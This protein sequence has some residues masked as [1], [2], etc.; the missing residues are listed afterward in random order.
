[1]RI[2]GKALARSITDSLRREIEILGTSPR[3]LLVYAGSDPVIDSYISIK[4][5]IADAIG[6]S[7][8]VVRFMDA[9]EE[10]LVDAIKNTDAD[11]VVVQLPLPPEINGEHILNSIPWQKDID[12]LSSESYARF[13][14]G[15]GPAI[16]PVAGA[17]ETVLSSVGFDC[18]GK[19][20]AVVGK[21]R[22]VGLPVCTW[23]KNQG[24]APL[25]LQ[26]GDDLSSLK[27][28]DLII[29]GTGRP[30]LLIDAG[31]SVEQ[32]VAR[33]DIDPACEEKASY[34]SAVPGGI[35]PITVAVLFRNLYTLISLRN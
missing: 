11:G 1:M 5:K 12:V 30:H 9:T 13:E 22:L 6:I 33:G 32:G 29:S 25:V 8:D 24:V 28:A 21:G 18:K 3:V 10:T 14:Q 20:V 19:N 34:F 23:L 35:G 27:D 4:A 26:E 16:P 15:K 2:D 7:L 31:T 17:I